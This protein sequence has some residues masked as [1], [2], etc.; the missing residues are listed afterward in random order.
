MAVGTPPTPGSMRSNSFSPF[1]GTGVNPSTWQ[2]QQSHRETVESVVGSIVEDINLEELVLPPISEKDERG[3]SLASSLSHYTS[4][5]GKK[6]NRALCAFFMQLRRRVCVSGVYGSSAPVSIP[7]AQLSSSFLA[8]ANGNYNAVAGTF[9]SPRSHCSNSYGGGG[10]LA[11]SGEH[12]QVR[13]KI[14]WACFCLA[15]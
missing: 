8:G 1:S 7:G 10:I 5:P 9:S 15:D 12:N 6:R 14:S 13:W 3:E 4:S 11:S 2:H